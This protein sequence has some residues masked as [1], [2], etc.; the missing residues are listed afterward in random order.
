MEPRKMTLFSLQPAARR[1][2]SVDT[3]LR[4]GPAAAA[5]A[6]PLLLML[7]YRCGRQL[8]EATN[9][10]AIL[11]AGLGVGTAAALIVCVP[12]L[13]FVAIRRSDQL[14][15]RRLAH[16]AFAAPPL[17]TVTGILFFLLGIPNGDYAVWVV[18]WAAALA[19]AARKLPETGTTTARSVGWIRTAHG[20]SAGII[21]AAFVIWHLA[22]H[23]VALWSL[24]QNKAVMDVLRLWYRSNTV[25]P[26]LVALLLWQLL[27]GL[28]L[29][30]AK[31]PSASDLYSS[32]QTAT[33]AYLAVYVSSHLI[34][35]FVLGRWFLA[36][37]TTFP[38]ASG[39]PTGLL[40]DPWSVRLIPHYSLAVLFLVS[41]FAVGLRTFL[42]GHGVRP[43]TAA[44]T[45]WTICA[46]GLALTLAIL[47]AQLRVGRVGA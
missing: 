13:G 16:L 34:A 21:I 39:A 29:L 44:R 30:W 22:N 26:L 32:I 10:P 6:Y 36:V 18:L 46:L 33:A 38:W 14:Q 12:L 3:I 27:S 5:L 8:A 19:Y 45:T 37:D 41:H 17:F 43:I 24:D 20:L 28:R 23:V 15:T 25:Q 4:Y 9:A 2:D 42:L 47:V 7:L 11:S 35:V 1:G 31:L 40:L